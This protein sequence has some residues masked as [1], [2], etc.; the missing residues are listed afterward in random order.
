[1]LDNGRL[2]EA[3]Q[4]LQVFIMKPALRPQTLH[5]AM[6]TSGTLQRNLSLSHTIR[7]ARV[8]ATSCWRCKAAESQ[9]VRA[10]ADG[11][12]FW[13]R[14]WAGSRAF[15][16]LNDG[17]CAPGLPRLAGSADTQSP[18]YGSSLGSTCTAGGS[19]C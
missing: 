7:A 16:A 11:I 2:D 1:M 14:R 18:L 8:P 4:L 9:T 17:P 13:G 10:Q 3:L 5:L 15:V 6:S 12:T 19:P